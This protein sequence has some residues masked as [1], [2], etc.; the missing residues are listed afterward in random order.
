MAPAGGTRG[1]GRATVSEPVGVRPRPGRANST[2]S[3]RLSHVALELFIEK[4]FE[5]VTIEDIARAGGIARRTFFN[6]FSSKNE[7]PWGDFDSLLADMESYLD[8]LPPTFELLE[9]L[10]LATL[11]FNRVPRDELPY[12]R[13]R[14]RVLLT[15]P[16]LIAHSTLQYA[17]WRQVIAAYTGRR[18]GM[19]QDEMLPQVVG[20]I[21]LSIALAAYERWL[22]DEHAELLSLID[23]GFRALART[24]ALPDAPPESRP[25]AI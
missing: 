22:Q 1:V 10:R 2:T 19:Y 13:R 12:H 3:A 4:G 25:H 11:E 21:C 20:H 15:S 24:F 23:D 9:A 14:M 6:Y 16:T 7:L 17:S 8:S 18:L 5:N